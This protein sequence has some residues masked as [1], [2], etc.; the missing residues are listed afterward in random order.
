MTRP[1]EC[2]RVMEVPPTLLGGLTRLSLLSK[3]EL[4]VVILGSDEHESNL[5]A[6]EEKCRDELREVLS[7]LSR[8]GCVKLVMYLIGPHMPIELTNDDDAPTFLFTYEDSL[9][10][11]I[12]CEHALFHESSLGK[13]KASVDLDV[14]FALNAG[15]WGYESWL[16]TLDL[17]LFGKYAGVKIIVT[18]Y[19]LEESEDDY[20]KMVAYFEETKKKRGVLRRKLDWEW[21]CE[22]NPK[23]SKT[24]LKR[25]TQSTE[26][27][28]LQAYYA[29]GFW[30]CVSSKESQKTIRYTCSRC[31]ASYDPETNSESS[32]R[33]HA[34]SYCGETAQR[35]M[36]P[37]ETE[38]AGEIHNFYSCC[39]NPD[40]NSPGC[41]ATRHQSYDEPEDHASW[42]RRPGMGI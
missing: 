18:S 12:L 21:D 38:G 17:L 36:A 19:T 6:S 16:P 41:C 35:W 4:R 8:T 39:S 7:T 33:Y 14:I 26:D 23:G 3:S 10:V 15:I 32:C 25:Q 28:P 37:G 22:K 9:S 24:D 13:G 20:D 1:S 30:Q 11:S 29:S 40:P 2:G 34:E 42:G 5:F 27:Q 31:H